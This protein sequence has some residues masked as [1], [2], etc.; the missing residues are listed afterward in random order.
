MKQNKEDRDYKA[1]GKYMFNI[2]KGQD[3]VNM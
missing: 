2:L 1:L 3:Q